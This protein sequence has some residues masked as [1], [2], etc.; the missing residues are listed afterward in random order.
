MNFAGQVGLG[1]LLLA[2]PTRSDVPNIGKSIVSFSS[3]TSSGFPSPRPGFNRAGREFWAKWAQGG[4]LNH[5]VRTGTQDATLLRR[6]TTTRTDFVPEV[7][8]VVS[9]KTSEISRQ[10][11]SKLPPKDETGFFYGFTVEM[12]KASTTDRPSVVKK[13]SMQDAMALTLDEIRNMR[14][15]ME[16][17]RKEMESLKQE[18]AP[19]APVVSDDKQTVNLLTKK[20]VERI[21]GK[22]G[23][24][25][26]SWA[27]QMLAEDLEQGWVEVKCKKALQ[28]K[29][30]PNETSCAYIKWMKDSRT[31]GHANPYDDREYPCLKCSGIIDAPLEVVC[32]YL[33]QQ[34]NLPEYNDLVVSHKDLQE[35]TP[36]SK[37]CLGKTPQILFI[38]ERTL[39]T[40]CQHRWLA[41]GSQ[42]IVNQACRH[43][44]NLNKDNVGEF[45]KEDL[46][47]D[48]DHPMAFALRGANYIARDP[49]DPARKTRLTVLAHGNP[50][51]DV[52]TWAVKTAI[53]ALTNLEPFKLFHKMNHNIQRKLPQL[54]EEL[55]QM[56]QLASQRADG[57]SSRPAGMSQL[58]YACFWPTGGGIIDKDKH[59]FN[60][61]PVGFIP[62]NI[63]AIEDG[64]TVAGEPSNVPLVGDS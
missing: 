26:E 15:E 10:L 46:V 3:S 39:I 20:E 28:R 37:I 58:G 41:D 23:R 25:V 51:H 43:P 59:S 61:T 40:F 38:K 47:D 42:L 32:L 9:T 14:A 21:Y 60:G 1:I 34:K 53:G 49:V 64:P 54:Q 30:N 16:A 36:S 13:P 55:E 7:R 2:T 6:A 27:E 33:S 8:H 12:L 62:K 56:N 48:N 52:P 19:A 44:K 29:L 63:D 31:G 50:G 4:A 17:L 18:L 22:I 35:I 11:K 24:D 57:R 45:L 5:L